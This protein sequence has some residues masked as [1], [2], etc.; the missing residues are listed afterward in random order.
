MILSKIL[1]HGLSYF[2]TFSQNFEKSW[3]KD[4]YANYLTGHA[5]MFHYSKIINMSEMKK[6][7]YSHNQIFLYFSLSSKHMMFISAS[8]LHSQHLFICFNSIHTHLS[9]IL[10]IIFYEKFYQNTFGHLVKI[11]FIIRCNFVST[12]FLLNLLKG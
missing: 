8:R 4:F 1:I 11:V 3:C 5:A 12:I 7:Q 6:L 10:M 9:C 2:F